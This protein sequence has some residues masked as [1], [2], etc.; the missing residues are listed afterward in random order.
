[1][2]HLPARIYPH[3]VGSR[4]ANHAQ[5]PPRDYFW[6][7]AYQ[8]L[9]T[10]CTTR[11]PAA[12][13]LTDFLHIIDPI[14]SSIVPQITWIGHSTFLIQCDGVNIL[15]D[16]VF[17][18]L[19]FF[20]K[21]LIAPGLAL[22]QVPPIDIML[23]SHNHRDHMDGPS[24]KVLGRNKHMVC[25]VPTGDGYWFNRR[26]FAH[27]MEHTWWQTTV[28]AT[29]TM[30]GTP[31]RISFLPAV[32]WSQRGLFDKNRSLWGS[33][34]I[35]TG[36]YSIYFAGDTAY[37]PHFTLI[38]QHFDPIDLAIVPIGPCLPRLHMQYTHMD[39][40]EAGQAWVDLGA[41]ACIPMHWGTFR[42]G[43]DDFDTPIH[44]LNQWWSEN[45]LHHPDKSL[46]VMK[47]GQRLACEKRMHV[48][49]I[50]NQ[51]LHSTL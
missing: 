15:T 8:Y 38:K 16:P 17:G 36:P 9:H 2:K 44:M 42:F 5:E 14:S 13:T 35:E 6:F 48:S 39:A 12:H 32:H 23:L 51:S 47:V 46:H 22:N 26:G 25:A 18:D 10:L 30:S 3:K 21:R 34:L 41:P 24:L 4:Y 11:R 7:S 43:R 28:M 20:Y 40:A 33:W 45:S 49:P 27:V 31:L 50:V 1:M 29:P 19:S 37:S